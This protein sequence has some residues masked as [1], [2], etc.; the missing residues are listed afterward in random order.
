MAREETLFT[1]II[2]GDIP[3]CE[4]ARGE[5]WLAFLDINPR[6]EGH[7][8][9]VPYEQE[10]RLADLSPEQLSHLFQGV[11]ETQRR[12]GRHFNTSDFSVGVHDGPI[13]GQEIPHVHIHVV[14]RTNGDGGLSMLA[15]WPQAPPP[16]TTEPDFTKLDT[17]ASSLRESGD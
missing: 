15:C 8:L 11:V 9:V 14:P 12:L 17:L 3:C 16:G 10:Q 6:R 4:V 1:K 13:A 2:N 7:T 5:A